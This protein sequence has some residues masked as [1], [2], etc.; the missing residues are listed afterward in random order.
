VEIEY[1]TGTRATLTIYHGN[2][3]EPQPQHGNEHE[4]E[5]VDLQGIETEAEMARILLDKGFRWKP[6][7][8][9]ARI[10]SI[11][12]AARARE[13]GERNERMEESKRRMEAWKKAR[14]EERRASEPAA[15][16]DPARA[17]ARGGEL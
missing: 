6:E 16:S 17:R 5:T 10:R 1:E 2:E 15:T 7:E 14:A 12:A 3:H 8:E 11:G 9:V 13:E 4:T